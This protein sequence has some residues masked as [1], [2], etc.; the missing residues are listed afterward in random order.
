MS[1]FLQSAEYLSILRDKGWGDEGFYIEY[2]FICHEIY[3]LK[4]IKK[5]LV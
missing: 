2:D 3:D 1:F 5:W 4:V